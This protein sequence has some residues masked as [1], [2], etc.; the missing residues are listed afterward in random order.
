MAGFIRFNIVL[1]K[2]KIPTRTFDKML[3][4]FY[5]NTCTMKIQEQLSTAAST[6]N[7]QRNFAKSVSINDL[8]YK[9]F[10]S[11][12]LTAEEALAL[13]N[14]DRYRVSELNKVEGDEAFHKRYRELQVMANLGNYKEFLK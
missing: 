7:Q 6:A 2:N 8:R 10:N 14:F 12:E 3:K 13:R 1:L 4:Y 11:I 9:E 5:R